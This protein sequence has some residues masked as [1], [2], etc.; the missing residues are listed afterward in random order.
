MRKMDCYAEY[1]ICNML[2]FIWSQLEW[3]MTTS[4]IWLNKW[5]SSLYET[6]K[7]V[8]INYTLEA[9]PWLCPWWRCLLLHSLRYACDILM[10]K[11]S[12]PQF[13]R[14]PLIPNHVHFNSE[15]ASQ[16]NVHFHVGEQDICHE[17]GG[18]KQR[19]TWLI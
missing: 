17:L 13:N 3:A 14:F 6:N 18:M 10:S 12:L 7:L 9:N 5:N 19:K 8:Y 4:L 11:K 16:E 15:V 2:L 1:A